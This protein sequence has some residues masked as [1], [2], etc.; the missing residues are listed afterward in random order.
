MFDFRVA[1]SVT[2]S[3]ARLA[4]GLYVACDAVR[5]GHGVHWSLPPRGGM[6]PNSPRAGMQ[7]G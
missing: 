6:S 1:L 3:V 7:Q 5:S 2:L 4:L